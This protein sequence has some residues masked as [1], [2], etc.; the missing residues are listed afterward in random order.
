MGIG[1]EKDRVLGTGKPCQHAE[2]GLIAGGEYDAVLAIQK[3]RQIVLEL[4]VQGIGAVGDARTGRPGAEFRQ[5][6][7]SGRDALLVESD[8][9]VVIGARK[10]GLPPV[11]NGA[12]WREHAIIGHAHC[13]CAHGQH[14]LETLDDA[15]VLVKQVFHTSSLLSTASSTTLTRS[16]RVRVSERMLSGISMSKWSSTSMTKSITVTESML[17]SAEISVSGFSSIPE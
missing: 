6:S 14:A 12:R 4:H 13:I 10:N 1:V 17:R 9:H 2:I 5:G 3:P 8:S 15:P 16:F 7:L 11:D